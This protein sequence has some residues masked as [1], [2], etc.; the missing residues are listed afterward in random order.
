M[1]A[2]EAS[3]SSCVVVS[4]RPSHVA[5]LQSLVEPR[6]R[7][8]RMD[9]PH[10]AGAAHDEE[11]LR[12]RRGDGPAGAT[13]KGRGLRAVGGYRRSPVAHGGASMSN[14]KERTDDTNRNPVFVSE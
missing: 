6:A 8:R 10:A 7:H 4:V 2:S 12:A 14:D 3:L 1:V 13:R 5:A 11:V 9:A